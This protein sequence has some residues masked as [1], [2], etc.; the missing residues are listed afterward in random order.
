ME[1]LNTIVAI[2]AVVFGT[3]W[4]LQFL[5]YT[6]EKRKKGAA[7]KTA[8]LDVD[9]KEDAMKDAMLRQAYDRII[10]LQ[11]IADKERDKWVKIAE[12]LSRIKLE[13]LQEKEARQIAERDMCSVVA[14][15]NRCPPR[16]QKK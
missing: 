15:E 3:G 5:Y 6:Y 12:E 7:A 9:A 2:I 10:Q 11:E 8:E 14:C 13:L 16:I 1:T 4:G